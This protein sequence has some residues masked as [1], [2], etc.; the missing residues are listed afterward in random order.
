MCAWIRGGW[1][2][3]IIASVLRGERVL[4]P[5]ACHG[6]HGGSLRLLPS[7]ELSTHKF[8]TSTDTRYPNFLW[9]N[10][11]TPG[12]NYYPIE[13]SS[14]RDRSPTYPHAGNNQGEVGFVVAI[15]ALER[16]RSL[17]G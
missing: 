1:L 16:S 11:A 5:Q 15:P 14:A 7:I 10:A 13:T 2:S 8:N 12:A 17:G 4:T 3:S 9:K 6:P